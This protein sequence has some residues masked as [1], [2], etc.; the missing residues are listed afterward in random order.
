MKE[1]RLSEIKEESLKHTD[2]QSFIEGV[3]F[4]L[5]EKTE[6]NLAIRED[7]Q[8]AI[9]EVFRLT[10]K[11]L[12][13]KKRTRLL[14]YAKMIYA[15][16]MRKSEMTFSEIGIEVNRDHSSCVNYIRNFEDYYNFIPE[17]R[18]LVNKVNNYLKH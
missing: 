7:I 5:G 3:K 1:F 15:Y 10:K 2:P 11:D 13:N 6:R 8:Q 12:Q 4:C 9:Y 17:F 14:T 18:E 16:Y